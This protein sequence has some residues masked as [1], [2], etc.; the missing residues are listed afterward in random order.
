MWRGHE[1]S[2]HALSPSVS[3]VGCTGMHCSHS[4]FT[5]AGAAT[6]GWQLTCLGVQAFH[7]VSRW[8]Y[9]G[10][11]IWY[12]FHCTDAGLCSGLGHSFP[13]NAALWNVSSNIFEISEQGNEHSLTW[14]SQH[15]ASVLWEHPVCWWT[16]CAKQTHCLQALPFKGTSLLVPLCP[17]YPWV[18]LMASWDDKWVWLPSPVFLGKLFKLVATQCW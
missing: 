5:Q 4:V 15:P 17:H 9:T 3:A 1:M 6:Q 16:E 11:P 14:F 12:G 7:L 2:T 13:S 10:I 18:L 8:G